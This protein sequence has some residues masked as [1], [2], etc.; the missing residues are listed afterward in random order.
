MH[1]RSRGAAA[2][3][4]LFAGLLLLVTSCGRE[5]AAPILPASAGNQR[6]FSGTMTL[7]GSRQTL[8]F[9]GDGQAASFQ[10]S[11]TA[12]LAG[13]Q[14]PALGYRAEIIGASNGV[15]GMRASSV[16]T[17]RNGER[18]FSELRAEETGPDRIVIGTFVGG[19]GR[20]AGI[21][22][23]YRFTWQY[24]MNN[25]EGGVGAR[26]T[27][28]QGWVRFADPAGQQPGGGK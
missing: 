1:A 7:S 23:E 22:G 9:A 26:I 15:S 2:R 8:P 20:Y 25:E 21:T 13:E 17:D 27:D 19:T 24:M 28:L 4:A 11:G 3:L 6:N 12:L 16:W 14:R 10:L 18:A 5:E